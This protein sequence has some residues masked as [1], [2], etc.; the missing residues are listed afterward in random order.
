MTDENQNTT[1]QKGE[2]TP[3]VDDKPVSIV[4]EARAIRDEIIKAKEE[5]K[6]EKEELQKL[7]SEN[8]LSGENGGNVKPEAPKEVSDEDYAKQAMSGEIGE[9]KE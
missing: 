4:E 3:K 2:E 7:Q 5:L 9:E 8:L 6:A 1:E